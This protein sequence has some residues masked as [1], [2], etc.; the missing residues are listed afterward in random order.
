MQNSVAKA[1]LT[2]THEPEKVSHCERDVAIT[3]CEVILTK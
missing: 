2:R 1:K 3:N